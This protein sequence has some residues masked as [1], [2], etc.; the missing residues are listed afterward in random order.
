MRLKR[1][2]L[3]L[4][5]SSTLLFAACST[6]SGDQNSD[7]QTTEDG[8]EA[9][10]MDDLGDLGD[11]GD[12][13]EPET[14]NLP[15][16]V[17]TVNDTD[18]SRDDFIPDF[19]GQLQQMMMT[20]QGGEDLDQDEVKKDVADMVVDR[21][22]LV[23]AADEDNI[24]ASDDEVEEVLS[25]AATQSGAE[26]VDAFL[27][28]AEAEGI[29]ADKMRSDAAKQFQI[30]A[31]LEKHADIDEPSDEEL[32][33]QYDDMLEQIGGEEDVADSDLPEFE[34]MRDQLAE[35][36]KNEQ[37]SAAADEILEGL[38]DKADITINL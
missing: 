34:D 20:G 3:A 30:D 1:M 15:D 31:Y 26:S 25:Q 7:D 29:S 4:I 23:Q 17:A 13:P 16:V 2:F 32:Q 11:M 12:M 18:I 33:E 27:E 24:T 6:D 21:E 37:I 5:C 36:A 10:G 35:Q 22:L 9:D 8:A 14:D 28:M 19:E 38:R